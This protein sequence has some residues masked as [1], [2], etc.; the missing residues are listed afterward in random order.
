[1]ATSPPSVPGPARSSQTF[2]QAFHP[3]RISIENCTAM[4]S[5]HHEILFAAFD[6]SRGN[7]SD[8]NMGLLIL[9][10]NIKVRMSDVET[11]LD[12]G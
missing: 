11:G 3:P 1:M 9:D 5:L 2:F 8:I 6:V 7:S 12:W 4:L 10:S